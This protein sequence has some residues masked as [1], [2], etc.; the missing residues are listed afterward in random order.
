MSIF[1]LYIVKYSLKTYLYTHPVWGSLK[2]PVL[3]LYADI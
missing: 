3:I 2:L 1:K